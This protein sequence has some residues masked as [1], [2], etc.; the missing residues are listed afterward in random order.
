MSQPDNPHDSQ[1]DVQSDSQP[2]SPP[3]SQPY[4]MY[5]YYCNYGCEQESEF[6][7][8]NKSILTNKTEVEST[9]ANE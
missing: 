2:D 1:P 3:D 5:E 9:F 4:D 8:K 7:Q 6:S